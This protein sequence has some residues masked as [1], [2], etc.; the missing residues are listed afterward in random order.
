LRGGCRIGNPA[1]VFLAPHDSD[2]VV[3]CFAKPEDAQAFAK[4]FAGELLA[5]G[6]R[7]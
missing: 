1:H 5:T 4:R 6:S 7:R 2:F 3:F